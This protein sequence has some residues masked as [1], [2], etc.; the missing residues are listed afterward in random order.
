MHPTSQR[1]LLLI[2]AAA[3]SV[4]GRRLRAL[5]LGDDAP[6]REWIAGD[7]ARRVAHARS[8][9]RTIL[10]SLATFGASVV[11]LADAAYP[12]GLRDLPD[13]PAFLFVRGSLPAG[14]IAIVGSRTPPPEAAAFAYDLARGLDEPVVSG[15]AAG[16]DAAAHRGALDG[17]V[18][19]VAYVGHGFGATY[20]REHVELEDAIAAH[21]AVATDRMPH[22]AVARSALLRRDRLQA[23]HARAIVL[24][25][26]E[27]DGGAME[28]VRIARQLGRSCFVV[29]PP[30]GHAQGERA[31]GGNVRAL[32]EGATALPLDCHEARRILK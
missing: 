10:A 19:T 17:G 31:W 1:D 14:G 3:L 20:P 13:A 8:E 15:L 4:G 24:I 22:A 32:S 16:I 7:S 9:A 30:R 28:T 29:T 26:T 18:P 5:A 23:A 21:G 25:A 6:L 11:T 12:P 2:A 27:E